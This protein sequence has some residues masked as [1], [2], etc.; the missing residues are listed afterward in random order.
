MI[1]VTE[2]SDQSREAQEFGRKI[3]SVLNLPPGEV[4]K[5]Q[6]SESFFSPI[7][8]LFDVVRLLE[9]QGHSF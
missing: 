5:E 9:V 7:N 4:I 6:K 1:V 2:Q 3:L 8:T